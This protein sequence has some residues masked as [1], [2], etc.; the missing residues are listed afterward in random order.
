MGENEYNVIT[1][2]AKTF[3]SFNIPKDTK[4]GIDGVTGSFSSRITSHKGAWP[5]LIKNQLK[6]AGYNNVTVLEKKDDWSD[7][8][9]MMIDHGMEFKGTFNLFGGANDELYHRI[10]K[11]ENF[12]GKIFSIHI[13]MPDVGVLIRSRYK[14]GTEL[15]RTLDAKLISDKCAQVEYFDIVQR[16]P[17]LVLGD[18]HSFSMYIPKFMVSRNDGLTMFGA[19]KRGLKTFIPE[20]VNNIILYFGNIDIR[21][22]ICRQEFPEKAVKDMLMNYE[23]QIKDLNLPGRIELIQALPIE[24]ESRK[25]PKTGYYKGTPFAGTWEERTSVVE[26]FNSILETICER[27]GWRCYKHPDCYLNENKELSFDVM[28]KPKSVH[29]SREYYRWDFDN[30]CLNEKLKA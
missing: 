14:T 26:L 9:L 1:N 4:I 23:K 15:F 18:S 25:L 22:H 13:P 8:D 11:F 28:E 24:N 19:L 2:E 30:D 21:H 12:E 6:H 20:G 27:N 10:K 3:T 7:Y 17:N 29:L 16:T 5:R